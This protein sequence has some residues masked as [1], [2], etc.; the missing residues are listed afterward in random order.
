MTPAILSKFALPLVAVTTMSASAPVFA[1]AY[2]SKP[3]K[4]VVPFAPGGGSDFI[5]RFIAQRLSMA[6]GQ[7]VIIDNRPGAGGTVGIDA[8]LAVPADGYTVVL[9]ASSY[10]TNTVIYNKI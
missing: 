10:T 7:P 5:A 1:Q 6:V 4:I 2:P 8:G 3:I 9:I